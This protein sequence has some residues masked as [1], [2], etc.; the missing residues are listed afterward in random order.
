MTSPFMRAF[1]GFAAGA[2]SVLTF[3]QGMVELL[4]LL[5]LAPFTAF[6]TTP[7]R[8][9]G[10]PLV[11][12]LSF[13]GGVYGALFGVL[14]TRLAQPLWKSGLVLGLIAALV[15]MFVVAPIKG[16]PIANNWM[17]WPICRSLLINIFWGAGVGLILPRL[18][19]R[20]VA[21]GRTV[22]AR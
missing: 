11:V 7:I 9:L 15:G 6:R 17:A 16:N 8:P 1:L 20:A 19:P 13:W 18:M 12:D 10:V 21:G 5:G 3:H 2:I 4:H 14:S 22:A